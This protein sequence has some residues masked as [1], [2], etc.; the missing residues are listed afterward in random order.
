MPVEVFITLY[1]LVGLVVPAFLVTAVTGDKAG[2]RDL[3][4]RCL[5]W[6][7]GVHW[8]LIALFGLLA[9]TLLG[10]LPFLGVVPLEIL[11][12]K[13]S[14]LFT[15]FLPGVVGPLLLINLW[16]EIGWTG[17]LQSTAT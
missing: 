6:R 1:S 4:G 8:Y 12:E 3:L 7:V 11:A 9:T 16:E 13:W 17:F 15:V 14:L 2:V 5:R 10:V